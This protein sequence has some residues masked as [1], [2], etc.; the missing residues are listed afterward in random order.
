MSW[1]AKQISDPSWWFSVVFAGI[2]VSTVAGFLKDWIARF[3][4]NLSSS[5]KARSEARKEQQLLL[6]ARLADN[7]DYLV[8]E[9]CRVV[10]MSVMFIGT[11]II[12][13]LLPQY[14]GH[15]PCSVEAACGAVRALASVTVYPFFGGLSIASGYKTT[16]RLKPLA[17]AVKLY[18]EKHG[19]PKLP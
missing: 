15:Q 1:L 13:L 6:V 4:G 9:W 7:P 5:S 11:T 3:V 12:F 17:R 14:Q 2:V 18:R 8:M 10:L 16:S 19:L